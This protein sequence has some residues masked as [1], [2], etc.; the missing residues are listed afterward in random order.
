IA[1]V[2]AEAGVD[3]HRA[4]GVVD[5]KHPREATLEGNDSGVEDAVRAGQMVAPDDRVEAGT[6]QRRRAGG[7]PVLP[8]NRVH[9]VAHRNGVE[10]A[11]H[12][13]TGVTLC[14]MSVA[15]TAPLAAG[16]AAAG[17]GAGGAMN[18]EV[19]ST[20][21]PARTD[22]STASRISTTWAACAAP[23][24]SGR[25]CAIASAS[26]PSARAQSTPWNAPGTGTVS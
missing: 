8:G 13:V 5:P 21:P 4:G 17:V 14:G 26:S 1:A 2:G 16:S 15:A 20:V 10:L 9:L 7:R 23:A 22:V 6:P 24:R 3:V 18:D 25:S 12:R 19:T 11:A